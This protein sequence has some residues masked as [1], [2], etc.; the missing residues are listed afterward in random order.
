[1]TESINDKLMESLE[2]SGVDT[3]KPEENKPVDV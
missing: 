3:T 2:S 1:M